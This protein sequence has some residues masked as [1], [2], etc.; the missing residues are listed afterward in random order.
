M[1]VPYRFLVALI[2]SLAV[3]VA[4]TAL[5]TPPARPAALS[6]RN[7]TPHRR[8]LTDLGPNPGIVCF[9]GEYYHSKGVCR[10][11]P[12]GAWIMPAIDAF[13]VVEVVAAPPAVREGLVPSSIQIPWGDSVLPASGNLQVGG[14]YSMRLRP[15]DETWTKISKDRREGMSSIVVGA[16]ELMITSGP[17]KP[18]PR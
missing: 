3:L 16:R 11:T 5:V 14:V 8:A 9:R 6:N 4:A 13:K 1:S 7:L 15:D 2:G 17:D 12:D 18:L 10:K